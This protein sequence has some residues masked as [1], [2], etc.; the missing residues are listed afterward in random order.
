MKINKN[1][2]IKKTQIKIKTKTNIN[3]IQIYKVFKISNKIHKANH[4]SNKIMGIKIKIHHN[5][6]I[7]KIQ[8]KIKINIKITK[9][10]I[11]K[12]KKYNVLKIPSKISKNYHNNK[13]II[14]IN[15]K[16]NNNN[17]KI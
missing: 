2:K 17:S 3:K 11:N 12:I 13:K 7:R 6:I 14:R 5:N 4:K 1:N 10:K 8:I 16:I 15:I 9:H